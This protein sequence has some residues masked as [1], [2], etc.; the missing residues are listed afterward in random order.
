MFTALLDLAHNMGVSH[1]RAGHAHHVQQARGDG[2]PR[3][4]D[5][6]DLG[7]MEGR[8]A[9]RAPDLSGEIQM[10][11]RGHALDRDDIRHRRIGM[12][13]APNDIQKIDLSCIPQQF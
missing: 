3:G 2:V 4:R 11:R 10:R 8:H 6:L 5:I 1:M 12:D 9:R 7:S 13:T